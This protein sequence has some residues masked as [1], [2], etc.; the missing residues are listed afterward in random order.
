MRIGSVLNGNDSV[1][2][3]TSNRIVQNNPRKGFRPIFKSYEPAKAGEI[4]K[5]LEKNYGLKCSFGDN[6]FVAECVEKTTKV[7]DELFGKHNLP[8]EISYRHYGQT[9]TRAS[10]DNVW[11]T[12]TINKDL[13]NTWYK[14]IASLKSAMKIDQRVLLPDWSSTRH[15][16][17]V[18]AHEYSHC[19]HWKHLMQRN[20]YNDAVK[21]WHGLVGARIPTAIGR[22][23]ARYKISDYA[24]GTRDN[25]DM[26]EFLAERMAQDVC[27]GLT[28][29]NWEKYGNINVNYDDI[30]NRNWSYR[31]SSPQS[32]IDY[33]TQQVWNGDIAGAEEV[34]RQAGLYLARLDAATVP[35]SVA[36]VAI[37]TKST[38]WEKLGEAL[39]NMGSNITA[40]CDAR[41]D[42]MLQRRY[43]E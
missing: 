4:A 21:V 39:Y 28:D 7:F 8:K 38:F 36:K 9:S 30:F 31:Y 14:D 26:C 34:G 12:V 35:A 43:Y 13:D 3:V 2:V 16:A 29:T 40:R 25:C 18:F 32:Y 5:R 20:G 1:G 19:V 24:V 23:I 22:L 41:N 27:K 10:Y 33:F 15:P 17:Y 37:A 11:N 42:I 6:G